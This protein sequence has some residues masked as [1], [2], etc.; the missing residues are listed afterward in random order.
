MQQTIFNKFRQLPFVPY[1]IIMHLAQD[2]NIENFWKLLKYDDY[3]A[4][5]K[6]NL[7]YEEKMKMIWNNNADQNNYN[8]FLTPLIEDSVLTAKTILKLYRMNTEP[9]NGRIAT[10]TYRFDVLYGGKISLVEYEGAPC[11]RADVMEM[12]IMNS[13]NG[14]DIGGTI[15]FLQYNDELSRLCG[16]SAAIG[17]NQ[18]FAGISIVMAVQSGDLHDTGC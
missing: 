1:N 5:S 9:N 6:P 8:I 7:S 18:T 15:G 2:T 12:E 13:L 3:G 10:L 14:A 16:S 11:N 17:N 4:L